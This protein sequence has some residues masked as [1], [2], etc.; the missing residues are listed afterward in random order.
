MGNWRYDDS[1]NTEVEKGGTT[2]DNVYHSVSTTYLM[3]VNLLG[4]HAM[5]LSLCPSQVIKYLEGEFTKSG[6]EICFCY[7]RSNLRIWNPMCMV[8]M[9]PMGVSVFLG[10]GFFAF[11]MNDGMNS[12]NPVFRFC[13][14]RKSPVS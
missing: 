12:E 4:I 5:D 3:E 8:F 6:L 13:I 14:Q 2:A 9:S 10:V 11:Q 1:V 7:G